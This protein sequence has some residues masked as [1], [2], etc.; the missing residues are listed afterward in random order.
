LSVENRGITPDALKLGDL[1]MSAEF[2]DPLP[3][4]P[5]APARTPATASAELDSEVPHDE[6]VTVSRRDLRRLQQYDAMTEQVQIERE[7][8]ANHQRDY[9]ATVDNAKAIYGYLET[10]GLPLTAETLE[11]AF[12]ELNASGAFERTRAASRPKIS[13]LPARSHPLPERNEEADLIAKISDPNLPI[14][15][16]RELIRNEFHKRGLKSG[17]RYSSGSY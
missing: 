5:V 4:R 7:F 15:Q 12:Q 14:D 13:G 16:A 2:G 10:N 17:S 6:E 3:E 9:V 1:D 11:E 8:L